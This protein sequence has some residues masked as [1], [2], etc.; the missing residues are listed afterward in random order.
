[1]HRLFVAL[2]P[3]RP[4]REQLTAL[5]AGIPGARWQ[6]DEQ[7]H[8]TSRFI[9]ALD[10]P[11]AEDAAAALARIAT[12]PIEVA[13]SGVGRFEQRGRTD[14][15]WAGIAPRDSLAALHKI[16]D[17]ALARTG[18]EPEGRAYLPH[19]TLARFSRSAGAE[20][21]VGRW[22]AD[23]GGLASPPFT[24][25]DLILYESHLSAGGARYEIVARWPLAR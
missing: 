6:E 2:R 16:V 3:P 5:Q 20:H 24:L 15:V 11:A 19:I 4:I 13:L 21:D 22:L 25:T 1:M 23:H 10:R 14:A 9:G 8:L 12:A 18:L 7:L 17:A